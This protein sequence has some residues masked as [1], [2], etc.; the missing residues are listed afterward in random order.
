MAFKHEFVTDERNPHTIYNVGS[1]SATA[2]SGFLVGLAA[3]LFIAA[4][5]YWT[6]TR[7]G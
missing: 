2:L 1:G 7:R 3:G 5:F 4:F 6:G